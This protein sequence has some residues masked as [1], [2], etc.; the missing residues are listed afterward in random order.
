MEIELHS[1]AEEK[2]V[3][4]VPVNR[5]AQHYDG[6]DKG[7]NDK[8]LLTSQLTKKVMGNL[9]SFRMLQSLPSPPPANIPSGSGSIQGHYDSQSSLCSL[10]HD[11]VYINPSR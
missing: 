8:T 1:K 2:F 5:M 6:S 3:V 4:Q 10:R 7:T 11:L 9:E